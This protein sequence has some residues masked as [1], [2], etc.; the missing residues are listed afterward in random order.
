MLFV[1]LIQIE[2]ELI[3]LGNYCLPL[4]LKTQVKKKKY[5]TTTKKKPTNLLVQI[6]NWT[7]E[8]SVLRMFFCL[9]SCPSPGARVCSMHVNTSG[10]GLAAANSTARACGGRLVEML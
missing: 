5:E 9:T 6:L 7:G 8:M 4:R 10:L 1:F 3:K 2:L